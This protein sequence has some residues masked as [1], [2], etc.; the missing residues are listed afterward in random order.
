MFDEGG[1]EVDGVGVDASAFVLCGV[2]DSGAN[3]T[4]EGVR[5]RRGGGDGAGMVV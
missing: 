5:L 2:K 3:V 1:E 4:R